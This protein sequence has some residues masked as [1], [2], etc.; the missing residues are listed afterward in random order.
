MHDIRKKSL[1]CTLSLIKRFHVYR[2]IFIFFAPML[3]CSGITSS[4]QE[5]QR[6]LYQYMAETEPVQTSTNNNPR[7]SL[8]ALATPHTYEQLNARRPTEQ[9]SCCLASLLCCTPVLE[10]RA[11][12]NANTDCCA[13]CCDNHSGGGVCCD[14]DC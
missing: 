12:D 3:C 11:Y 9:T 7:S 4:Q 2:R 1:S 6:P 13:G 14:D 10:G 5:E 8:A